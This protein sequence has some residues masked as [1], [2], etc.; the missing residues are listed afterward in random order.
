MVLH[1]VR[2]ITPFLTLLAP[3][4]HLPGKTALD[5][6]WELASVEFFGARVGGR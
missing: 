6:N 1:M 4:G 2:L 5:G 3:D